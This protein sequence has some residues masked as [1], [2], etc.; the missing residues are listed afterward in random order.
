VTGPMDVALSLRLPSQ[1]R[2][3]RIGQWVRAVGAR[4]GSVAAP[5]GGLVV[6]SPLG[7]PERPRL[8]LALAGL[9]VRVRAR[10]RLPGWSRLTTAIRLSQPAPSPARLRIAALFEDA[11]E[12][13]APD[14]E[15]EAWA[16]G[17][18]GDHARVA[19]AKRAIRSGMRSL[20]VD[21]GLAGLPPRILTP[22]HL[23]DAGEVEA[24]ASRIAAALELLGAEP[25]RLRRA[26][27]G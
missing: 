8:A 12:A 26:R 23:A 16:I 5:E 9:G 1:E 21:F 7:M 10:F 15:G 22:F 13:V 4:A 20:C 27:I 11:W 14:G 6:V 17:G 3:E 24:E 18:A 19:A 2:A 25:G